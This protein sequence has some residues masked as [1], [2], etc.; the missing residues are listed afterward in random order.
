MAATLDPGIRRL[1]WRLLGLGHGSPVAYQRRRSELGM[2]IVGAIAVLFALCLT[3]LAL[4][5]ALPA[6]I[7]ELLIG[8]AVIIAYVQIVNRKLAPDADPILMPVVLVLNGIGYI[9][10]ENLDPAQAREQVEWTAIGLVLYAATLFFVRASRDLERYRYLSL[11]AAIVLLLLPLF[12]VIGRSPANAY[13]EKLWIQLHGFEIQPVEFAKILLVLFFASYV[14]EKR[15]LLTLPTRR[16]GSRLLPDLRTFGPLLVGVV[17]SL[18]IIIAERDIGFSLLLF[19]LFLLLIWATT[20]RWTY[21]VIGFTLFALAAFAASRVLPQVHERVANWL[22]PWAQYNAAGQPGYQ[23]VQAELAFGRGGLAGSGLGL[24]LVQQPYVLPVATSD[25]IFAALGEE[26]GLFGTTAI[27]V[28]YL[29]IAASGLRAA[30]RARSEFARMATLGLTLTLS[31]QAIIIMGGVTRVLPD[32]GLT[33]PFISYGG[34]ALVANYILIAIMQRVSNEGADRDRTPR[35]V[36][37]S[38]IGDGSRVRATG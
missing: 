35:A 4:S 29:L 21:V 23:P 3:S 8:V 38:S 20:G 10:I 16:V 22:N 25:Y 5:N 7:V 26:L 37:D 13:G 1:R 32:T 9:M 19:V 30:L 15:E 12:P 18:L 27:L 6:D 34:S 11:V 2:L 33:L 28:G 36:Y 14:I 24:G 17:A 31:L